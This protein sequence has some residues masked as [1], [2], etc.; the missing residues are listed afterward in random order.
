MK[1]QIVYVPV[2]IKSQNDLP[3]KDGYYFVNVGDKYDIPEDVFRWEN[4]ND[5]IKRDWLDID[6]YLQ[7]VEMPTEAEMK[8][9]AEE[10][11]QESSCGFSAKGLISDEF[12]QGTKWFKDK[13]K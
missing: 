1:K 11:E 6:W 5:R 4:G 2:E 13:L 12:Y 7:P 10:F 3:T 9:A 8:K